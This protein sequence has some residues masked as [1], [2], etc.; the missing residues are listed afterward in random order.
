MKSIYL[1]KVCHFNLFF[2]ILHIVKTSPTA[3][4]TI[5]SMCKNALHSVHITKDLLK[6]RSSLQAT[7]FPRSSSLLRDAL[8]GVWEVWHHRRDLFSSQLEQLLVNAPS[9]ETQLVRPKRPAC[10]LEKWICLLSNWCSDQQSWRSTPF[11]HRN[12]KGRSRCDWI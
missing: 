6:L 2:K 5:P 8:N 10:F 9:S 1:V 12:N 7:H 11:C 3:I 4:F